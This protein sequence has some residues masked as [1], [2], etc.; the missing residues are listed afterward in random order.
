MHLYEGP[1]GRRCCWS[2]VLSNSKNLAF[3]SLVSHRLRDSFKSGILGATSP[4]WDNPTHAHVP[5][6]SSRPPRAASPHARH[7][8]RT[9]RGLGPLS[10][11]ETNPSS[12]EGRGAPAAGRRELA[13]S[14][15]PR[16]A[17]AGGTE[18]ASAAS[19]AGPLKPPLTPDLGLAP[20]RAGAFNGSRVFL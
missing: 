16:C 7:T 15:G 8:H 5:A 3:K 2:L 12:A 10:T 6:L 18:R 13:G 1:R 4:D 19:P 14:P 20:L 17:A 9:S 11:P